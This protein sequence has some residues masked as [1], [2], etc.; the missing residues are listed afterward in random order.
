MVGG[1]AW[2]T[3][4]A[5]LGR[6]DYKQNIGRAAVTSEIAKDVAFSILVLV[7]VILGSAFDFVGHLSGE[8]PLSLK[9][10]HTF[11]FLGARWK[12]LTA[13]FKARFKRSRTCELLETSVSQRR[14][15]VCCRLIFGDLEVWALESLGWDS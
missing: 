12:P 10:E 7:L 9:L 4:P 8:E 1:K 15:Q 5:T 14:N 2:P 3:T 6:T 13:T 11:F